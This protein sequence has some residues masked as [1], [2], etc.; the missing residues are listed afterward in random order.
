MYLERPGKIV[1]KKIRVDLKNVG[2]IPTADNA[3]GCNTS[4]RLYQAF[5][6]EK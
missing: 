4:D 5:W 2:G 6:E 1:E 3:T